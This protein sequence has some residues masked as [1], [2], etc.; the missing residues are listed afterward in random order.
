ME[1]GP[2]FRTLTRNK[3]RFI[4]ISLE[5]A[6]TLAIVV[7]C[8]NITLHTLNQI[9]R[10][11]GLDEGGIIAITSMPF[12]ADFKEKQYLDNARKADVEMMRSIPGV[13]AAESISAFPLSGSGSSSGY[14]PLGDKKNTIGTGYFEAGIDILNALGV[15]LI[16]GRNFVDSDITASRSKNVIITKAFADRLFPRGDAL[17][18]QLQS[19]TAEYP[20]TIVGI[21]ETMMGSW[22]TWRNVTYVTFFPDK[23]GNF[24]WGLRY[25]VRASPSQ[26]PA[27]IPRL[28]KELL[29]LNNGRNVELKTLSEMKARTYEANRAVIKMLTAVIFLLVFV[30]AL[31]I[32][33]ITSF[34]V[35][36]RTHHIGTRRALGARK[37]DIVRYF[38][39][40]N[41]IITSLGV[42]AGVGF[43]YGLNYLLVTFV[44]GTKMDWRLV[45][46]GVLLLWFTGLSSAFAPA[47][48]GARIKPALA[49]R[50]V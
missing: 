18:K 2:I 5:V 14:K 44:S 25:I 22:P 30:T 35:T 27:L 40:E 37:L 6:L 13:I 33:G 43:T 42:A 12:A 32:V 16:Q 9:N 4:L 41:W 34:S 24:N 17:G 23:P 29:K 8:I 50:T 49:T 11:T 19:R 7:N 26:V 15:R 36:E 48:R 31:G 45:V 1:F 21:T 20:H 39:L 3:T 10:S 46:G 28:E 38:L 47:L